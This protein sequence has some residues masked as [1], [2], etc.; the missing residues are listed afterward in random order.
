MATFTATARAAVPPHVVLDTLTDPDACRRWSPVGFRVTQLHGDRLVSGS[1]AR[2]L[3]QFAGRPVGFDVSVH[4]AADDLLSLSADGPVGLDVRYDVT[5][6][7]GGSDVTAR[8][9][10]LQRPGFAGRLLAN[11]SVSLLAGGVLDTTVQRIAREA[12]AA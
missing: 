2:V 10:V 8:I 7:H 12:V 9:D 4:E 3:G 1:Q 5:A 6:V 11:A